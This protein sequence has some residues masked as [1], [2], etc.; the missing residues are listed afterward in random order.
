[1]R[2]FE[3]ASIRDIDDEE[4]LQVEANGD[5][6]AL[7]NLGGKYYATADACPATGSSLSDGY[8]EDGVVYCDD[9]AY[10]YDIRSGQPRHDP[11]AVAVK[12]YPVKID[13]RLVYVG[14]VVESA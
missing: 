9:D 7:F 1:K 11:S 13:G 12:R 3:V 6:I 2:W 4:A 8:I 10:S 14:I 5:L